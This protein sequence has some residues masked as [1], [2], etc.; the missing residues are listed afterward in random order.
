[1]LIRAW[2]PPPPSGCPSRRSET[3]SVEASGHSLLSA[4]RD[5]REAA[6]RVVDRGQ[7]RII[8]PHVSREGTTSEAPSWHD[9]AH[10]PPAAAAEEAQRNS[11]GRSPGTTGPAH[12]ALSAAAA[13]AR[14][15][16][17]PGVARH[18]RAAG[19]LF[20]AFL[21][22]SAA[23]AAS[24]TSRERLGVDR[25][26]DVDDA[27]LHAYLR[28]FTERRGSPQ[29]LAAPPPP[30][31]LVHLLDAL[32]ASSMKHPTV[33]CMSCVEPP[34]TDERPSPERPRRPWTF[35][36]TVPG[37]AAASTSRRTCPCLPSS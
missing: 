12:C 33:A 18:Q 14:C 20:R 2:Q 5:S 17:R 19:A 8:L 25:A 7:M 28:P 23:W 34:V 21:Q 15:P 30:P 9:V 22:A 31:T 11:P 16:V 29:G 27:P 35:T 37:Q 4:M 6:P 26:G 13:A 3:R 36:G 24:S 10:L 32:R 1:M